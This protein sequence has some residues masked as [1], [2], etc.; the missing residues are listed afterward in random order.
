MIK[1]LQCP[2]CGAPLE[3][4]PESGGE[5]IRCHFCNCTA[6][7]PE[8]SRPA[9]PQLR[10]SFSRP[11]RRTSGSPTVA[12]VVVGIIL[13]VAGLIVFSIVRAVNRTVS[14]ATRAV[15]IKDTRTT[16]NP[17]S[18]PPPTRPAEPAPFFGSEGIGPGHFKDARSIALDAEGRIYVGEYSGGRIQVFDSSGKFLTQWT[19]DAKMPLRGL[20]ADRRGTV[21]VVQRGTIMRYEGMTGRQ[22][23]ATGAGGGRYDDVVATP[24]GGLVAFSYQARDDVVRI[25]PSGQV[26]KTIRA[27]VSGQTDRSELSIR[28][29]ADGEGN[30]YALG[31][32][33]DAVFKFSPDGRF[34]TRFGGDGDEPG[35]F[36][37]PGAIACD[38]QGRVYVA[39]FKGV[40]IFDPN[41]RYIGLIKVKGAAS[42]LAFNDRNELFVV[43]RTAVYKFPVDKR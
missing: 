21:Y 17:P 36:R 22:L 28:V 16:F 23:G 30:I 37:A 38:N 34:L 26:T 41:G 7:L 18:V 5:T 15:G 2:T 3:Y 11:Q 13:A 31:E 19:A 27:A 6:M 9:E 42:G 33:N 40:Q 10:V 20:A 1:T 8:R 32:F 24:D 25:D 29:A 35:L 39:D 14:T 4:D 12:L 43:A